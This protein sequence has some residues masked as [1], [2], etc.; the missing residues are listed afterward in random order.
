MLK[1]TR[2]E[3][4]SSKENNEKIDMKTISIIFNSK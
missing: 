2:S 3:I 4:L 1:K